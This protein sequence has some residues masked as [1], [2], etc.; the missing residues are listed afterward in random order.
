MHTQTAFHLSRLAV[1]ERTLHCQTAF[2]TTIS[3]GQLHQ[4]QQN[5]GA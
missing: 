4:L 1:P 2:A 3:L 5:T